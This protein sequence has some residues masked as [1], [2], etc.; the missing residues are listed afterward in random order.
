MAE[1]AAEFVPLDRRRRLGDPPLG[2]AERD[3]WSFLRD[4]LAHEFG[5][6]LPVGP[7]RPARHLRVPARLEVRLGAGGERATLENLSEGGLFVCC[8]RPLAPG[9]PLEITI[10]SERLEQTLELEVLVVHSRPIAN[11]DGP[12]G[13]GALLE[14]LE[15]D[16]HAA[17]ADLVEAELA[18]AVSPG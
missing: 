6:P 10:E 3:R 1:L 17:L 13:F 12:A 15:P 14:G 7:S 2:A 4:A 5:Y 16:Q 11:H 18:A 9:T 8:R